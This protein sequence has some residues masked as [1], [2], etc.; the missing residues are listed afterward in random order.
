MLPPWDLEKFQKLPDDVAE[1]DAGAAAIMTAYWNFHKLPE[2]VSEEDAKSIATI[3]TAVEDF[4]K[5]PETVAEE[6]AM[7]EV[8]NE[9]NATPARERGAYE[10]K[11][12]DKEKADD[13]D[14]ESLRESSLMGRAKRLLGS[15]GKADV[16]TESGAGSLMG[17]KADSEVRTR[18]KSFSQS[19]YWNDVSHV[20]NDIDPR[21]MFND[22]VSNS[23]GAVERPAKRRILKITFEVEENDYVWQ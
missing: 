12:D 19:R 15:K 1:E 13:D 17:S 16:E 18:T 21:A 4:Q 14:G 7:R 2:N 8:E 9:E 6:D 3:M 11:A 5:L 23:D 22:M 20:P 10:E